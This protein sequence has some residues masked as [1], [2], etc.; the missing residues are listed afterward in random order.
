V[1]FVNLGEKRV[2][3][4]VWYVE[5]ISPSLPMKF[6]AKKLKLRENIVRAGQNCEV[7]LLILSVIF[8]TSPGKAFCSW[9][10]P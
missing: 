8:Y 9:R 2:C 3:Y 1:I 10:M 4:T 5:R 6:L 7:F